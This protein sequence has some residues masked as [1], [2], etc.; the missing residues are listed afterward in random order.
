M[1]SN[2][3]E[4]LF[5]QIYMLLLR[6][7]PVTEKVASIE[8]IRASYIRIKKYTGETPTFDQIL[9]SNS[10]MSNAIFNK[11]IALLKKINE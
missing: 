6:I 2:E 3:E 8:D 5:E 7:D 1:L 11:D 4:Q 9:C 10:Q